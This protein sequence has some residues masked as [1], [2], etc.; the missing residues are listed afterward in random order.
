MVIPKGKVRLYNFQDISFDEALA[1]ED[2][3]IALSENYNDTIALKVR[4]YQNAA[5]LRQLVA[6]H[7][8]LESARVQIDIPANWR[9]GSF[10]LVVPMLIYDKAVAKP[11]A[12]NPVESLDAS[13][14]RRV[15]LRWPIPS[16]C[17][18]THYPGA[19]LEKMCC[20]VASYIWMQRYCPDVRI[21]QLY[22]FGLSAEQHVRTTR[23]RQRRF[24]NI[25][26]FL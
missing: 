24:T 26:R 21:P 14:V 7:L 20:E 5:A 4:L 15:V 8:G 11:V 22:G 13:V 23:R 12:L 3:I 6:A 2:N 25:H 9:Q 16:R 18:E 19:L 1:S 10:N 17:G